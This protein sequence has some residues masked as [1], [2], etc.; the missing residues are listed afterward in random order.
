MTRTING[1]T[2]SEH[3]YC[4][5]C[6]VIY[7]N[8]LSCECVFNSYPKSV[9]YELFFINNNKTCE[10]LFHE[11]VDFEIKSIKKTDLS[12]EFTR[13]NSTKGCICKPLQHTNHQYDCSYDKIQPNKFNSE[14]KLKLQVS[15]CF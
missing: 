12:N 5:I 11:K 2:S 8:E 3:K 13:K 6:G 1:S 14:K 15:Y 10:P 4:R 7:Q 9:A